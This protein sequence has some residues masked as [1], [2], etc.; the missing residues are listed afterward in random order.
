[1]PACKNAY[2]AVMRAFFDGGIREVNGHLLYR[3]SDAAYA[4]ASAWLTQTGLA[5]SINEQVALLGKRKG[6]RGGDGGAA[7]KALDAVINQFLDRWQMEAALKTYAEAV[8]D[9]MKH[10][11]DE[12]AE[13]EMTVGEWNAFARSASLEEA[14]SK[15]AAMGVRVAWDCEMARTPEGYYQV[16][17]GIEYAVAKSLAVAPFADL[18]W[19]E[20][21][22]ADLADAKTFAAAIHAAFPKAMLAYN[23]SPSFNWDTTGMSDAEMKNFPVELGTL[24]YVFNFITYGGHQIDGLAGVRDGAEGGRDARPRPAA[25]EVPPAELTTRRRKHTSVVAFGRG[26]DGLDGPDG[27]EAMG[28]GSTSI[29]ISSD[30]DSAQGPRGGEDRSAENAIPG[31]LR[32]RLRPTRRFGPAVA[33]RPGR[34]GRRHRRHLLPSGPEEPHLPLDQGPTTTGGIPSKAPD[35]ALN[36]FLIHRYN[37]VAVPHV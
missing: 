27:T 10:G 7:E 23:L 14:A 32:V 19:M 6:A 21:K 34:V 17:G 9:A 24:G 31:S 12:G 28:K 2:L 5:V 29:N 30:R 25:A 11:I 26:A 35:D 1:M 33:E 37:A 18:I 8:A 15:A 22:S 36:V 16:R 20:T 13:W 3:V 4:S